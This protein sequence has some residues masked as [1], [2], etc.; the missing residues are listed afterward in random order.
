MKKK[1][2]AGRPTNINENIIAAFKAVVEDDI[3]AIICTDEELVLL[4]N[5]ELSER[6]KFSYSAFKDWKLFAIGEKDESDTTRE[7]YVKYKEIRSVYKKA[8]NKQKQSLFTK[9]REDDKAWQRW[10]WILERKFDDWNIKH[11]MDHTTKDD[12]IESLSPELNAK[13][14]AL[15]KQLKAEM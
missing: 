8:L 5:E 13:L 3:N 7:N 2:N 9:L 12:K 1:N 6:D 10:A 11:K 4:A 15:E 14:N